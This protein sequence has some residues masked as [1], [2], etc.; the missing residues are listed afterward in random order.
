LGSE[1]A[2]LAKGKQQKGRKGDAIEYYFLMPRAVKRLFLVGVACAFALIAM[3]VAQQPEPRVIMISVDGLMPSTYTNEQSRTRVPRIAQIAGSGVWADGMI[4]VTPTVT[5]PSHTTLITGVEPAIHGIVDN[6]ILD[7]ENL[8]VGAW[9]WYA[10]DIKAPTLPALAKA[11]GLR[12]AGI[13]WPVTV[14][15]DLDVLVPEFF[16]SRHP[17]ALSMLRALSLPRTLIDDVEA[18]RGKPFTWLPT[19]ADRAE[20]AAYAVGKYDP[21]LML[22]HLIDLDTAQHTYGPGSPQALETLTKVDAGVGRIVDAVR[23]AG[24]ADRTH[25]MIVSDHGF[26]PLEHQLQPNALFKREGLLSVDERGDITSWQAYFHSSGG[27][28]FVYVKD[29]ATRSR[30]QG[31][32][33]ALQR[34]PA[35]GIKEVWTAEQL[36]ARGAHPGAAFGLDMADGFYTGGAHDV[37][38]KRSTSKGGHG[39]APERAALHA[40]FVM[41]GPTVQKRGSL[42]VIRMISV[43]PTI[44]AILG[45]SLPSPVSTALSVG[46]R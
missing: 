36:A 37:L 16:R 45:V 27:A 8:S 28:G 40:S 10:R 24:R 14:G 33:E 23:A 44:G 3:P 30:V 12:T 32:L 18:A 25:I 35:N 20:L 19:D 4:G 21:H 7:P 34:D 1:N 6:R 42:G 22:V 5:Y 15:M 39:F 38:V 31:L 11:K 17:E 29:A 13:D 26:L 43:A 2:S 41:A 9:F 46:T